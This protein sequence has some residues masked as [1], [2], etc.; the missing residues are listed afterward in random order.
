[1]RIL[2]AFLLASAGLAQSIP[3]PGPGR[4]SVGG[5]TNITWIASNHGAA[6]S[7]TTG[8]IGSTNT[9]GA[10]FCVVAISYYPG[11]SGVITSVTDSPGN[12]YTALTVSSDAVNTATV[13]FYAKNATPSATH[14]WAISGN[15]TPFPGSTVACFNNVNTTTPFGH[16][17][18]ATGLV[19][20]TLQPGSITPSSNGALIVSVL[21]LCGGSAST[22]AIDSGMSA[23]SASEISPFAAGSSCGAAISYKIQGTAAAINPTWTYGVVTNLSSRI[24][25]FVK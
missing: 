18:G 11:A 3:F 14:T 10:N 21:G 17:S 13:L 16:E 12:T 25:D 23:P 22:F 7:S 15:N 19:T 6:T 24:A 5:G 20:A 1:M 8:A 4:A 9:T 2:L